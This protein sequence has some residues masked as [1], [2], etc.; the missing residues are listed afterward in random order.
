MVNLKKENR[1]LRVIISVGG[2]DV[3]SLI[4]SILANNVASRAQFTQS[5]LDFL[6]L[7]ECDGVNLAW[8][9]PSQRG[10]IPIDKIAYSVLLMDLKAALGPHDYSISITGG[11]NPILI[12]SGYDVS[13]IS[14]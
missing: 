10:G 8:M 12:D 2:W 4:F 9:H 11:N 13:T 5:V 7:Y 14:K 3:G 1:D 6:E